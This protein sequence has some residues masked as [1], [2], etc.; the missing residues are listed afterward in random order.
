[1]AKRQT[2]LD[3]LV[4]SSEKCRY[5]VEGKGAWKWDQEETQVGQQVKSCQGYETGPEHAKPGQGK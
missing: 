4:V 3:T 2:Q 1:M 5:V